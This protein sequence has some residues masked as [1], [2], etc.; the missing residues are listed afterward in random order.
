MKGITRRSGYRLVGAG[1]ALAALSCFTF[2]PNLRGQARGGQD[3]PTPRTADGH[4]D[5]SGRYVFAQGNAPQV[6][7]AFKPETKAK[8]QS[9]VPSGACVMGGTP[10]SITM[11]TTEHGP[12]E[13]V[14]RPGVIWILA[15]SPQSVI[16]IPTDGRP[17]SKDPD[18]SFYGESVGHWE[19]DTLVVDT[20]GIDTR[21]KNISVGLGGVA[22]AWTHSGKERVI[23]RFSRP[24]KNVLTYQVTVEDPTVLAKPFTSPSLSWSLA[25]GAND[26][27]KA[28]VPIAGCDM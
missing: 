25:Q 17:H 13:L 6:S 10:T 15:E 4:P 12:F 26:H 2:V 24:S 18:V 16:W 19:G 8:Y 1:V 14:Q 23:Q 27:W 11:Q 28:K 9:P 20:V 22:N 5:L 21:M 3:G 7:P